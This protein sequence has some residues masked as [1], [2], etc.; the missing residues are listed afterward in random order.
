MNYFEV[1]KIPVKF[2]LEKNER[3]FLE[4]AYLESQKKAHFEDGIINF[5]S[6][7]INKA[8]E[9]L[10]DDFKR[11]AYIV[12]LFD[13]NVEKTIVSAGLS[14]IMEIQEEL[15]ECETERDRQERIS[16]LETDLENLYT[17]MDAA[18]AQLQD[19]A[20]SVLKKNIQ[21][22]FIDFTFIYKLIK[23]YK[24]NSFANV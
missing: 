8:Y 14:E 16:L 19:K 1:F 7:F 6:T 11:C 12:K 15:E 3:L 21:S 2:R 18:L 23:K 4:D 20:S 17:Q 22:Y 5:T 13:I 10:Q 24:K 9:T